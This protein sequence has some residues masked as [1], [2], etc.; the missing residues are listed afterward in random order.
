MPSDLMALPLAGRP[1]APAAPNAPTAV[2][3]RSVSPAD[4]DALAAAYLAAYPAG[5]AASDL[6]EARQEIDDTF[7]GEF[8]TLRPDAT[9]VA[10]HAGQPVGAILVVERSIWDPEL[11]GPFIIDLFVHPDAQGLAVGRAL[12]DHAIHACALAGDATLSL[13]FGEGTSPAAHALYERAGFQRL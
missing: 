4:R 8:G 3:L 1:T 11:D 6:A 12:L 10:V 2:T 5:V 7:Q 9:T 13:R